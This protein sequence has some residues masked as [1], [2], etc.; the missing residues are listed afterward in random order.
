MEWDV[1]SKTQAIVQVYLKNSLDE[2]LTTWVDV[3]PDLKIGSY[4]TLKDFKPDVR[5]KVIAVFDTELESK[6]LEFHRKWDNNN[7][8]KHVGLFK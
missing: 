4:I 2:T 8:D 3:R 5:W 6:S 7:Y 1:M